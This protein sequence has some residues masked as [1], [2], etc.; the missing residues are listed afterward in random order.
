MIVRTKYRN[1][2]TVVDG[3]RFASKREADHYQNLLL[4]KKSGALLYFLR[5]VPFHLPGGVRYVL[6][7]LEFW[8]DGEVRCVDVKGMKTPMYIVKR[9]IVEDLYPIKILEV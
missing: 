5:Q 4:A 1:V 9:K 7:F 2:P 6:D 8:A 3:I